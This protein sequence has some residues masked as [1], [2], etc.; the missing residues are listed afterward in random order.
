MGLRMIEYSIA[1]FFSQVVFWRNIASRIAGLERTLVTLHL[2]LRCLSAP[3]HYD[4]S[5]TVL[6][7]DLTS[8]DDCI[9]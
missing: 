6:H 5:S 8:G 9:A 2:D 7:M 4:P 1:C 3:N